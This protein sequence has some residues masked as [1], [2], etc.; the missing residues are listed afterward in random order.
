MQFDVRL[1][2]PLNRA[3]QGVLVQAPSEAQARARLLAEG[4]LVLSIHARAAS[5]R[6]STVEVSLVC[7][8]LRAL[9][10]AGLTV[11]EALD[12]LAAVGGPG[13]IYEALLV[14]LRQG[15]AL[16][17]AME[18]LLVFPALLVASVRASERTSDLSH[19]LDAYLRFDDMVGLLRRKVLS[20]A[21]YPG[22]VVTLGGLVAVFLL[23][24][25]VPRFARLYGDNPTGISTSTRLLLGLSSSLSQHPWLVPALL[26]L[27]AGCVAWLV[28]AGRWRAGLAWLVRQIPWLAAQLSHFERARIYEALALLVHGG[29]SL[30]E[31]LG[32][33]LTMASSPAV[34]QQLLQARS[35]VERGASA[36]VSFKG[37]GLTD[38]ISERLI[39]AGERGGDFDR[40]LQAIADRHA[41]AFETFVERATRIVEPVLL[42]GVA[43]L[44]G[45]MVVL[46][47]MPVFD[48]AG[49]VR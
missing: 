7:R 48:I 27:L 14:R 3:V 20:A 26:A 42:I 2:D 47:Y 38:L 40:V 46:L 9:L 49:T 44:I 6:V 12:A 23:M 36:S 33:C 11:V 32:V 39:R 1:L 5:S 8:E 25:V 17:A 29:Y 16:S 35:S 34:E 19:A 10:L 15:K 4:Q 24:V 45:S 41:G 21:L 31:A 13:S 18:D 37:A 22:L 30:H 28:T 43:L